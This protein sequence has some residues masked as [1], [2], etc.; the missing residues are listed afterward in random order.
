MTSRT[1]L[2]VLFAVPVKRALLVHEASG[3]MNL[4]SLAVDARAKLLQAAQQGDYS[5]TIVELA[6]T[7]S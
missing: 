5:L 1:N 6:S 4:K 3:L 7:W 2:P